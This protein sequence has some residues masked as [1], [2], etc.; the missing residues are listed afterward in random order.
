M[1]GKLVNLAVKAN[2]IKMSRFLPDNFDASRPLA[3]I[4]GQNYPILLAKEQEKEYSSVNRIG[5]R[6]LPELVSSFSENERTAVKVGQ[7]GKLKELKRL[8]AY[9]AV[10]GQTPV[11]FKGL[12]PDLKLPSVCLPDWTV[13]MPR[14]FLVRLGM[15]SKRPEFIYSMPESSWMKIWLKKASW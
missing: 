9:Y 2:S 13:K 12:H 1:P 3:L 10:A 6:N 8:G 11:S 5:R 7:V 15:K 14:L 4:A